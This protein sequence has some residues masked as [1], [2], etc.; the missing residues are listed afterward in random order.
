MALISCPTCKK[1]VN[2]D[3]GQ[4]LQCGRSVLPSSADPSASKK[5]QFFAG[6]A[7]IAILWGALFLL[8]GG[9]PEP[10]VITRQEKIESQ[11]SGFSGAHR[12]L[13]RAIKA[14]MNNPDSYDHVETRYSDEGDFLRI[15]TVYR[16]TN[17]FGGM[18]TDQTTAKVSLTGEVLEIIEP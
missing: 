5:N 3:F 4:C 13:E 7:A 2:T 8:F 17:A 6:L 15:Q 18:V 16:G 14:G 12:N 1:S 11:F 9:E 10:V